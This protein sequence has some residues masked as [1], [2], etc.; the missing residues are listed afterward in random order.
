MTTY[1]ASPFVIGLYYLDSL[2]GG[3]VED[4]HMAKITSW[5]P[6]KRFT[7]KCPR[8]SSASHATRTT[9]SLL[10]P[11]QQLVQMVQMLLLLRST[12]PLLRLVGP[13]PRSPGSPRWDWWL[14]LVHHPTHNTH[15]INVFTITGALGSS[16]SGATNEANYTESY[17]EL[18]CNQYLPITVLYDYVVHCL[19]CSPK[20]RVTWKLW[21]PTSHLA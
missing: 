21:E 18:C 17:G 15:P 13:D 19:S 7:N 16:L 8:F 9:Q 11:P 5:L 3:E 2:V 10:T 4:L 6:R 12:L 20:S 14:W 1:R